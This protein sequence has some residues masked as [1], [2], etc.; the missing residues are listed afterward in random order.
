[1]QHASALMTPERRHELVLLIAH[2]ASY[3]DSSSMCGGAISTTTWCGRS[4]KRP[5]RSQGHVPRGRL[6]MFP[7][8]RHSRCKGRGSALERFHTMGREWAHAVVSAGARATARTPPSWA[9]HSSARSAP[10]VRVMAE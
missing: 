2:G 9:R 4:E 3:R 5:G 10:S 8:S 1:M 6:M 7:V